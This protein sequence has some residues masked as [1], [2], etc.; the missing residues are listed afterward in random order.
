MLAAVVAQLGL[1]L[2][3]FLGLTAGIC[4]P[5]FGLQAAAWSPARTMPT[6][7][8]D[9]W[10]GFEPAWAP[11][12]LSICALVPLFPLLTRERESLLRF[13]RGLVWL[14]VP[15]FV[16]FL[17]VPVEGPSRAG[18]GSAGSYAWLISVDT[19]RNAFPSLHA[20]L[21]VYCFLYG[22]RALGSRLAQPARSAFLLASVAWGAAILFSTLATKQHWALD[23]AAG[24][25]L[26]VVADRMARWG[27]SGAR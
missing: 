10:V 16:V 20:G 15:C 26:A 2:R 17:L 8:L 1:K 11:I 4:L 3:V 19:T 25:L 9:A 5:Y 14:C 23:I 22:W 13:A 12:Y 7:P 6:T 27:A 24:A 18:L 21:T